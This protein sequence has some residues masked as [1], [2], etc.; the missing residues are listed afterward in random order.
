MAK[1]NWGGVRAGAGRPKGST[2]K[3][4][5]P[6][7]TQ[8]TVVAYDNEWAMIKEFTNLCKKDIDLAKKVLETLENK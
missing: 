5:K 8:H 3:E 2:N 7:R 1:N 4:Q 6:K